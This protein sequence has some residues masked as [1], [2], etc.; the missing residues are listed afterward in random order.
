MT[1][2]YACMLMFIEIISGHFVDVDMD[3]TVI[4]P[5]RKMGDEITEHFVSIYILIYLHF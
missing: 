1:L 5:K 4:A 2:F 3:K